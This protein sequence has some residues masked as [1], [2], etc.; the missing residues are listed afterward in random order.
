VGVKVGV[1]VGIEVDVV[2]VG[3]GESVINGELVLV[4]V[5]VCVREAIKGGV[6]ERMAGSGDGDEI[7]VE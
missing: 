3:T 1:K 7:G 6:G 4:A 5:A 2:K